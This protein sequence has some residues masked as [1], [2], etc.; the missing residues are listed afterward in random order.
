MLGVANPLDAAGPVLD[1]IAEILE[2]IPMGEDIFPDLD[3]PF[4]VSLGEAAGNIYNAVIPP[5]VN[6]NFLGAANV[7]L[8]Q[9]QGV[10][11][12]FNQLKTQDQK[13]RRI[14]DVNS[15]INT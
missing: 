12:N 1:R 5:Q 6:N 2:S 4:S 11:P 10:T 9:V 7:N 3:N 14:S 13:L 8:N 15:L